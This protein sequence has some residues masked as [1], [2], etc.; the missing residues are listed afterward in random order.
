MS[1]IFFNLST[2]LDVMCELLEFFDTLLTVLVGT[3]EGHTDMRRLRQE[4]M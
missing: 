2:F 4:S 1:I 3:V